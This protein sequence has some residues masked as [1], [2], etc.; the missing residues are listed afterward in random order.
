[1]SVSPVMAFVTLAAAASHSILRSSSN[2]TQRAAD[3]Q[4]AQTMARGIVAH[5]VGAP[6]GKRSL[7]VHGRIQ[8]MLHAMKGARGGRPFFTSGS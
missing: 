5:C 2:S 8:A 4:N 7:P 6:R 3:P 1:M